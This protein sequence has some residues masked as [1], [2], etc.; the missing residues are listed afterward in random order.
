MNLIIYISSF[1]LISFSII[2]YGY[3]FDKFVVK[4]KKFD[5]GYTGLLGIFILT[6]FVYI[7]NLITPITAL[8]NLIIHFFVLSLH[9][10]LLKFFVNLLKYLD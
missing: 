6:I 10:L 8:L 5:L 2:G 4:I 3:I 9:F 7:V 1:L